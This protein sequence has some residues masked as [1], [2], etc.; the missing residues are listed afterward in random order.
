[1]TGDTFKSEKICNRLAEDFYEHRRN[2][3]LVSR[4]YKELQN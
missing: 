3:R 1:M 2:K 4:I